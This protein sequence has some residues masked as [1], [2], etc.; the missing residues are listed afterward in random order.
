MI[1]KTVI[2]ECS[3]CEST[4]EVTYERELVS[5]ELPCFCPFCGEEIEEVTEE[6]WDEDELDE[7]MKEWQDEW[8]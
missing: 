8:K 3:E 7:T 5:E 6:E 1:N 2:A 4:F